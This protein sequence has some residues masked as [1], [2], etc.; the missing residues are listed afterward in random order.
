[1]EKKDKEKK[2]NKILNIK[3]TFEN[4]FNINDLLFGLENKNKIIQIFNSDNYELIKDINFNCAV[5]FLG[6]IINKMFLSF[7]NN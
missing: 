5:N 7:D 2:Y 6:N 4:L 1:M 3:G